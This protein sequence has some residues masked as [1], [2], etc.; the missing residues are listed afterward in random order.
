MM[1]ELADE[2][3]TMIVVTHEMG[4]ARDVANQV[5]FMD[6]GVVVEYGPPAEVLGNPQQERTKRFL[7]LVLALSLAL[8][9]DPRPRACGS[10]A[11]GH[12]RQ[13]HD[14][15]GV[16]TRRSSSPSRTRTSSSFR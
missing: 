10:G 7:G 8:G 12:R 2:G 5:A 14:G 11:A 1:R 16:A 6:G 9:T 15:V 4:F 13:D 3:M